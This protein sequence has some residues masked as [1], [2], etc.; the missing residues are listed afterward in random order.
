VDK[1]RQRFTDEFKQAAVSRFALTQEVGPLARELGVN[2]SQLYRWA[3]RLSDAPR[4]AVRN[5]SS[6]ALTPA[7]VAD[8]AA[9]SDARLAELE[10]KIGQQQLDLDFFRAALR[11]VREQQPRK[12]VPGETAS[13]R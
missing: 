13:T 4:V 7:A 12:G 8:E 5:V 3:A 6:V 9:R 11:R 10:R 2:R 1:K